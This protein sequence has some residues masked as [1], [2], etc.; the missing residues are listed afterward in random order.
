MW[1]AGSVPDWKVL[2][3][4]QPLGVCCA[5]GAPEH[6]ASVAIQRRPEVA[7]TGRFCCAEAA[8][9]FSVGVVMYELVC[10]P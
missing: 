7:Q 4:V 8:D 6:V 5:Y 1:H 2:S 3:H 9:M 10:C